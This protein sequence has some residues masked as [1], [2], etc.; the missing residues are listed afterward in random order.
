MKIKNIISGLIAG[1]SFLA[2][3]FASAEVSS[4]FPPAP[5]AESF[6]MFGI[7]SIMGL[8]AAGL[9]A[10]VLVICAAM[11]VYCAL[12]LSAIAKKTN[13]EPAWLA[14]IP[15]ANIYLLTK[16]AKMPWWPMLLMIGF[17]IPFVNI[18]AA[19]AIGVFSIIWYWK[20]YER[21]GRPGW[22]AIFIIIPF[23]GAIVHYVLLGIA[24][25]GTPKKPEVPKAFN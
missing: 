16:I 22:W 19:I 5:G 17:V 14:W 6:A 2:P 11:Y 7:G 18:L 13:T 4:S 1:A 21:V 20:M 12:A 8:M 24:A 23:F 15:V 3:L 10:V 9:F 25:W